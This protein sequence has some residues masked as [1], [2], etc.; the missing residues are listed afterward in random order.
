MKQVNTLE[1]ACP[2]SGA[3]VPS[4]PNRHEWGLKAQNIMIVYHISDRSRACQCTGG[5]FWVTERQTGFTLNGAHR[6][7]H[8]FN[9]RL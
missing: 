2:T 6:T 8:S 1:L 9:A 3:E 4:R 7:Y 5:I